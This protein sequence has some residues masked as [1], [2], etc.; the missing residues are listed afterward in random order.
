LR[1][2]KTADNYV[3]VNKMVTNMWAG[4]TQPV[5]FSPLL[6]LFTNTSHIGTFEAKSWN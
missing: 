2:V 3:T 1:D 6:Y 5:H 4:Y